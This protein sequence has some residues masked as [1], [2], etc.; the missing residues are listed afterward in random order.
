MAGTTISTATT[1]ALSVS[2][3]AQ[4]PVLITGSGAIALNSGGAALS[5]TGAVNWTITN[6]GSVTNLGTGG[7]GI[8][9][10][11]PGTITNGAS[12]ATGAMIS[13]GTAGLQF[14][15]GAGHSGNVANFG[16]IQA[17]GARGTAAYL[18]G[19]GSVTNGAAGVTTALLIGATS[20]VQVGGGAGTVTNFGS[21]KSTGDSNTFG[22]GIYFSSGGTI[23]NGAASATG[24]LISGFSYGI[25]VR[26]AFGTITNSGTITA[27][28]AGA[29]AIRLQQGGLLSNGANGAT[30]ALIQASGVGIIGYQTNPGTVTNAGTIISTADYGVKFL[31]GGQVSNGVGAASALIA[32]VTGVR[33]DGANT[34]LTN[35]GT[36]LGTSGAAARLNGYT[37][38]RLVII[39]GAVFEQD[40][41][42]SAGVVQAQYGFGQVNTME[43]ASAATGGTVS[44]VGSQF[45]GFG[46]VAID[47]GAI[48]TITGSNS[49]AAGV[50]LT[51]SGSLV[52]GNATLSGAASVINN[53]TL[54][55]D[56]S[57]ATVANLGGTGSVVLA[58]ASTLDLQGAVSAGEAITLSGKANLLVAEAPAGFA[59]SLMGFANSDTIDFSSLSFAA[60][61]KAV[62]KNNVLSV[63]SNGVTQTLPLGGLVSGTSFATQDDGNGGTAVVACFAEGTGIATPSGDVPVE[64]LSEGDRVVS[65]FG[66]SAA[67]AWLG[68]RRIDCRSHPRPED[69]W[70]VRVRQGA[71]GNG[72]PRRDLR[73]SPDHAVFVDGGKTPAL[74]PVRYLV[75]GRSIV[76]E[77]VDSVTYWHVELP[78][79]DVVLAEG[80]P[81]ESYLDTGN[82]AAFANGGG[83]V[84]LHADLARGVWSAQSCAELVLHG[85]HLAAVRQRL[86]ALAE[87]A[88]GPMTFEPELRVLVDGRGIGVRVDG[89]SWTVALPEGSRRLRLVSRSFV[90]AQMFAHSQDCR[91]LGV[92]I[93]G[94]RLDAERWGRGWHDAEPGDLRW[95]GGDA[96][97]GVAGMRELRFDIAMAGPY[98]PEPARQVS[99][100]R[101][102]RTGR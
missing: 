80:L 90:P 54:L 43:L 56:P 37:T 62:V 63:T 8:S 33:L 23:T 36:I 57:S 5:A 97:L 39:P 66:G 100:F 76:Q 31:A 102:A 1:V 30:A 75:N 53:G 65:G 42:G 17:T 40:S 12:N 77:A 79:H 18:M 68:Y 49:L 98:W 58:G 2:T 92:A 14:T 27:S 88:D 64:N 25:S 71:F 81:C 93:A 20:G 95:T 21:I 7:V 4:N 24:A 13:G 45:L 16:T 83:A 78:A 82:R 70:P 28:K 32:G 94:L 47:A 84:M 59:G 52:L 96:E 50:T 67:V 69:V 44:G 91:R 41:L 10:N 89:G 9:I 85:P 86:L 101:A 48:W 22:G 72:L 29:D 87:A 19:G 46:A 35:A 61:A 99:P 60:D 74:I 38:N 26:G 6:L 15:L 11:D 34:T 55:I 73:L 3:T 51:N